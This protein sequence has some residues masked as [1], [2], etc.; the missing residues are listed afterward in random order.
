VQLLSFLVIVLGF[1]AGLFFPAADEVKGTWFDDPTAAPNAANAIGDM[2]ARFE[3]VSDKRTAADRK[4][5]VASLSFLVGILDREG[6]NNSACRYASRSIEIIAEKT[7]APEALEAYLHNFNAPPGR[8][9]WLIEYGERY[10]Q[11]ALPWLEE[12]TGAIDGHVS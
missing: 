6:R 8:T 9:E 7:G 3:G 5:I 2:A 4:L 12:R 1:S 10:F 11:R